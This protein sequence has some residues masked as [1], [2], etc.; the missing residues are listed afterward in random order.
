[1]RTPH[2]DRLSIAGR[3]L[4]AAFGDP[5]HA[6]PATAGQLEDPRIQRIEVKWASGGTSSAERA[7]DSYLV[8]QEG[9]TDALEVK[10]IADDG[11][12]IAT[13]PVENT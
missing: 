4:L 5:G 11:T 3:Y 13:V 9:E 8:T 12:Q 2:G 10:F 7:E 6:F 1:M